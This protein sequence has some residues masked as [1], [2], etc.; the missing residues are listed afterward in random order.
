MEGRRLHERVREPVFVGFLDQIT[1]V[2]HKTVDG[3]NDMRPVLVEVE[4]LVPGLQRAEQRRPMLLLHYL[5]NW[6]IAKDLRSPDYPVFQTKYEGDFEHPSIE[7]AIAALVQGV[8]LD[9]QLE[10]ARA[11]RDAYTRQR[12]HAHGLRL[13]QFFESSLTLA[14]AAL[15]QKLGD[16]ETAL[17]F[18]S[19][20]VEDEPGNAKFL[21]L[22][23]ALR[24]DP[25]HPF[26]WQQLMLPA[27]SA[28]AKDEPRNPRAP[29]QEGEEGSS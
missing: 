14:V 15:A 20:A 24:A 4:R 28:E 27:P 25:R 11:V 19:L 23:T 10:D 21:E 26:T 18:V 7:L 22:E 3:L 2:I 13:N 6:F 5:Y 17:S 9:W 16:H 12:R 8:D 29:T 1:T